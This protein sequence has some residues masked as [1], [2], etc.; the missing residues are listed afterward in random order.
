MKV[1]FIVLFTFLFSLTLFGRV[2]PKAIQD[3]REKQ[4]KERQQ[5]ETGKGKRRVSPKAIHAQR[6]KQQ[7]EKQ[8]REK[9]QREKQQKEKQ[10]KEKQQKEK[11]QTEKQQ[12]ETGKGKRRV[13][14]K[15]IQDKRE[16]QRKEARKGKKQ[17]EVIEVKDTEYKKLAKDASEIVKHLTHQDIESTIK[18]INKNARIT[19]KDKNRGALKSQAHDR[20]AIDIVTDNMKKDAAS[21]S[22]KLGPGYIVIHE[23]LGKTKDNHIIYHN[24]KH[25]KTRKVKKKASGEHL[26]IQP[27]FNKELQKLLEK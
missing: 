14:P 21:I 22:A 1:L 20:G 6:E 26:H 3:K 24:G 8:Q 11:Q 10:Q 25:I 2:S 12:T 4:R 7:K 17:K 16:K 13:S 15:A 23:V 5:T 19:S 27:N 9:Q 18:T